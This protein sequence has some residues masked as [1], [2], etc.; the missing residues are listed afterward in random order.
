MSHV[1]CLPVPIFAN[2][3]NNLNTAATL[4]LLASLAFLVLSFVLSLTGTLLMFLGRPARARSLAV[5]GLILSALVY[6]TAQNAS[7]SKTD[8]SSIGLFSMLAIVSSTLVFGVTLLLATGGR[9]PRKP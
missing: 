1:T 6:P 5:A 2:G 9:S 4:F 7:L 8:L 3:L